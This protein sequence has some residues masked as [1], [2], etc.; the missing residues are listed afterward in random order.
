MSHNDVRL[1]ESAWSL[2]TGVRML[3]SLRHASATRFAV[4]GL[5]MTVLHLTVFHLVSGWVVA[6]AANVT[7]F[8]VVTQVNFVLSYYWTWAPR[9]VAGAETL[10]SVLR[11]AAL[12]NGSAA[13]GFGVNAAIFSVV[14]RV[15][16]L[17][18]MT[19]A[20]IATVGSAAASFVLSS[21]VVFASRPLP[22]LDDDAALTPA[23]AVPLP[24]SAPSSARV[25]GRA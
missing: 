4:V 3:G 13:L 15:A 12:F 6:E 14:Y 17:G 5:A 7:A 20:L 21:R 23:L 8:V 25:T 18:P 22:S 24:Q 10:R 2:C 16:G 9:R 1:G 11:R 19:S